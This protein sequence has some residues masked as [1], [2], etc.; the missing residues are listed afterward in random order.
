MKNYLDEIYTLSDGT[1]P[2]SQN[3]QNG[4]NNILKATVRT[5]ITRRLLSSKWKGTNA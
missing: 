2:H 3:K 5:A 1:T 4:Q